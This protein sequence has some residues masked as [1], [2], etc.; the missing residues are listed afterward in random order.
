LARKELL[1][2]ARGFVELGGRQWKIEYSWRQITEFER[3]A[4]V[5]VLQVAALML[6]IKADTVIKGLWVA[7]RQ[8]NPKITE[9]KICDYLD[10][11]R[12]KMTECLTEFVAAIIRAM[13]EEEE[14]DDEEAPLSE[15]GASNAPAGTGTLS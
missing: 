13:P 4:G 15:G 7:M 10:K 5:S 12:G 8:Q 9:N 3:I 11:D 6:A 14:D 2:K 1:E